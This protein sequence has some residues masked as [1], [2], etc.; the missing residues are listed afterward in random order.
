M[1]DQ[2]VPPRRPRDDR[3]WDGRQHHNADGYAEHNS[4]APYGYD[5]PHPY[6][7]G[8]SAQ[9]DPREQYGDGYAQPA[10]APRPAWA[11]VGRSG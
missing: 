10:P 9:A 3:G 1:A 2:N 8:Y 4:S 5:S 6:Q 11:A 7:G